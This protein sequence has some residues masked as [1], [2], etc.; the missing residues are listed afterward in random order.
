MD[1]LKDFFPQKSSSSS[2]AID[3]KEKEIIDS[4]PPTLAPVKKAPQVSQLPDV[5]FTCK[6]SWCSSSEYREV[7]KLSSCWGSIGEW[8]HNDSF[9]PLINE[10]RVDDDSCKNRVSTSKYVWNVQNEVCQYHVP[11][12]QDFCGTLS[13]RN[14]LIVGDS[15]NA[16]LAVTFA[17]FASEGPFEVAQLDESPRPIKICKSSN[18]LYIRNDILSVVPRSEVI[19]D[20]QDG[21]IA[22]YSW[23]D[24]LKSGEYEI[25]IFNRG[26]HYFPDPII[27]ENLRA[28]S[29]LLSDAQIR[30]KTKI[31]YRTTTSGH[32]NCEKFTL[33][34]SRAEASRV[35]STSQYDW[36]KFPVQNKIIS[37]FFMSL[38]A[39]IIDANATSFF[40]PDHHRGD[41]D[42]LHYCIPGPVDTWLIFFWNILA[43]DAKFEVRRKKRQV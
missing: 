11:T 40:R 32:P 23:I 25:A 18:L 5:P 33:P 35:E 28:L 29:T 8:V 16:E 12:L 13:N 38:G 10:H 9:V 15:L 1:P 6:S 19:P 36:N 26:A 24:Y 41:G 2:G 37:N 39:Y 14:I 20:V 27:R 17:A 43:L 30:A 42:C 22:E 21:N 3:S 7:L 34:L 31:F 4:P